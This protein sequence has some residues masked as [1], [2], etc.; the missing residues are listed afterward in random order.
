MRLKLTLKHQ[1]IVEL[2]FNYTYLIAGFIYRMI[3]LTNPKLATWLHNKGYEKQGSMQRYKLITFS[4]LKFKRFR[5]KETSKMLIIDK[6]PTE[7]IISFYNADLLAAFVNGAMSNKEITFKSGNLFEAN[8][9][10]VQLEMLPK[11]VFT[12][13]MCFEAIAPICVQLHTTENKYPQYLAPNHRDYEAVLLRNIANKYEFVHNQ[14]LDLS[15][16]SFSLLSDFKSKLVQIKRIRVR[17]YL[18]RFEIIAPTTVME[19]AYFGGFGSN[20]LAGGMGFVE[21][22]ENH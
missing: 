17:G 18:F 6:S 15:N 9:Y 20:C 8:F 5:I 12:E 1:N 7:L 14:Q 2:P 11:P 3:R 19:I 22:I 10:L 16:C 4:K 21:I 13:T